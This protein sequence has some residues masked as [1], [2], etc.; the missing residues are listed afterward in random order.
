M[1]LTELPVNI[2][3]PPQSQ[4][5][6]LDTGSFELWVNPTCS[7]LNSGDS[8]F[9]DSVG[10]FNSAQ[11]STFSSLGT[12]KSLRYG[13]GAA[14]ITYVKDDITLPGSQSVLRQLQFGVAT[15]TEDQF[16]G[17][18]GIGYGMGLTTKYPNFLDE[19]TLQ[20]VTKVKAFT[21]ALGS[22]NEQEGVIVFGGVDTSKF[23]GT[24]ARLPI[25][26]ADQS[27]DKVPRYWV[28]MNS[29][30]LNPPSQRRKTY[31]NSS[32]QVFLDSGSTLTLLPD[33]LVNAIAA[34]FG[35]TAPDA[36]GFFGVSCDLL[37]ANGTLDFAFNGVTIR[38]P[39]RELI[40]SSG[41]SCV[42]GL[43]GNSQFVLLGDT[44][45]RSAYGKLR[46]LF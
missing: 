24:L 1:I 8:M 34:D 16:S 15:S 21:I 29:I 6:Q 22:K 38:V 17:I 7:A 25:T 9:C 2:G 4:F 43:Q 20:N 39:Y 3:T 13:I 31:A 11:S 42:L 41:N 37:N 30:S 10:N 44:F 26:P 12:T 32:M 27:P 40:R 19:L 46:S 45:L 5:V 14:N 35:A 18:L 36:N 33:D 23:G 28:G